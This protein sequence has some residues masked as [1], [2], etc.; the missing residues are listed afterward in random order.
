MAA[1]LAAGLFLGRLVMPSPPQGLVAGRGSVMVAQGAL[2]RALTTQSAGARS[3]AVKV[4]LSFR[5]R[6][7]HYC[8]SFQVSADAGLA[9]IACRDGQAWRVRMALAT[10][11]TATQYQ[12]AGAPT[13]VLN[14]VDEMIA[15]EPLDA[16][17]E[18][19]ARASGWK[20]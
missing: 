2:D 6:D 18:A 17:A 14:A 13:A 16:R 3:G 11:S 5:S 12:T 20:P 4:G 8:R 9:G 15:G 1:C 19:A 10:P 7:N